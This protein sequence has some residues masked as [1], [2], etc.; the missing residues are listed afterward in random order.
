MSNELPGKVEPITGSTVGIG[1]ET[2]PASRSTSARPTSYS[3]RSPRRW[4]LEFAGKAALVT[5]ATSGIGKATAKALA[6]RGAHVLVSGRDAERGAGV[7]DSIRLA[8][9][10]ADFVGGELRDADSVRDLARRAVDLSEGHI[11]ILVNNA[12]LWQPGGPTAET[13]E[14]DIDDVFAINVKAPFILVGE[15][16]P[17]MASR[18]Y[19]SIINVI[20]MVAS[21][22]VPGRALYGSSKAALALLTKSWAAEFGPSGVRV[23]AVSPGPT[24]TEGNAALGDKVDKMAAVAPAGRVA[25]PSEIAAAITYLASDDA[26]FVHGVILPVDGGRVAS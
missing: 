15:L 23:N 20:T 24:R 19:G 12:A 4:R 5:G 8:G 11:D 10:E 16:A 14:S 7:A 9:G 17:L 22:G 18:G 26:S 1:A 6:A 2:A 21:F 25:S 13:P 3:G